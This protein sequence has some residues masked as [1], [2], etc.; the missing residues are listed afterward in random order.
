MLLYVLKVKILK[1]NKMPSSLKQCINSLII[2]K[3]FYRDNVGYSLLKKEKGEKLKIKLS[4]G[5]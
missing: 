3:L 1:I 5:K 2:D 4:K